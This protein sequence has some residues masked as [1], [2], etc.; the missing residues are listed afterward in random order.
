MNPSPQHRSAPSRAA[1][2]LMLATIALAPIAASASGRWYAGASFG[3]LDAKLDTVGITALSGPIYSKHDTD[4]TV[5]GFGGFRFNDYFAIEI[6][7]S[8]LGEATAVTN[9]PNFGP[10]PNITTTSYKFETIAVD[11]VAVGILPL[12]KYFALFG[13]LGLVSWSTDFEIRSPGV[14]IDQG[15]S[16]GVDPVIGAGALLNLGAHF[17]I[18]GEFSRLEMDPG[19]GGVGEFSIVRGGAAVIF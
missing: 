16:T 18:H 8:D 9:D 4:N 7:A 17:Q 15:T 5:R 10:P 1:T 12:G 6:G 3:E 19:D 14:L 13:K 2:F 11:A